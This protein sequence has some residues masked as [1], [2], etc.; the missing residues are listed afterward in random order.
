MDSEYATCV[1]E[2][3]DCIIRYSIILEDEAHAPQSHAPLPSLNDSDLRFVLKLDVH[4]NAVA[5][6]YS[7][8][9]SIYNATCYK[10]GVVALGQYRFDFLYPMNDWTRI[11]LQGNIEVFRNN[12]WLNPWYSAIASLIW[13]NYNINFISLNV[14]VL[15]LI[16]Y[17]I[18][19]MTKSDSN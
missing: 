17:I 7:I 11:T 12:V 3:I 6:K 1:V 13:S 5:R 4:S 14:N 19:Y 9:L 2:F 10:Y 18:N 16:W 15:A 8:H